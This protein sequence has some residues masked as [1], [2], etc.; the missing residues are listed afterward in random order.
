M[1]EID[2][3]VSIEVTQADRDLLIHIIAPDIDTLEQINA[4]QAFTLEVQRIA[5]HRLKAAR[6]WYRQGKDD[7]ADAEVAQIVAFIWEW[8]AEARK[9]FPEGTYQKS[10]LVAAVVATCQLLQLAIERGEY[11]ETSG[12]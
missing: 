12:E 5:E 10:D 2:Q 8:Q 4:G 3:A 9:R 7:G 1:T 11:K 6:Y